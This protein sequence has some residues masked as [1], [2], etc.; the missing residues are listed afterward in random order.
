VLCARE[1][2][3]Q[4]RRRRDRVKRQREE[5]AELLANDV[6]LYESVGSFPCWVD[7]EHYRKTGEIR[8]RGD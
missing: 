3:M 7:E 5:E 6:R 1:E 4:K 2:L 8:R